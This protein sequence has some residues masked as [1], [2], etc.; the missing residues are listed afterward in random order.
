MILR[1][2]HCLGLGGQLNTCQVLAHVLAYRSLRL[3]DG[4]SSAPAMT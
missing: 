2:H 3:F 4:K 1:L